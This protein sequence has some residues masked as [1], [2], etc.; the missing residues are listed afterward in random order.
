MGETIGSRRRAEGAAG[1]REPGRVCF[2][3]SMTP[4]P[5]TAGL[6]RVLLSSLTIPALPEVLYNV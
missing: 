1:E 5:R 2:L 6:R 4:Y 3:P